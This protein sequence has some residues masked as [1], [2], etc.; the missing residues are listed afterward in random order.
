MADLPEWASL[1]RL[2]TDELV[3]VAYYRACHL[4]AVKKSVYEFARI[5]AESCRSMLGDNVIALPPKK[6]P[7]A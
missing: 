4:P 5:S 3:L 2:T 6:K 1:V 7:A